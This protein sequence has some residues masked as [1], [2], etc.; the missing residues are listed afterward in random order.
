MILGHDVKYDYK[1]RNLKEFTERI[2][3]G[4]D[5]DNPALITL[6]LSIDKP[7]PH[8]SVQCLRDHYCQ[9]FHLLLDVVTDLL[10][11]CHWR[12]LC[13]DHIF[14]PLHALKCLSDCYQ[15]E[16]QIRNL[17][18]ELAISCRYFHPTF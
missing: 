5:A 10:V 11:P 3:F 8:L 9:Q 2:R 17:Y 12:C 18:S 4:R 15:S 14:K 7:S 1:N 16:Q 13:L 6:W